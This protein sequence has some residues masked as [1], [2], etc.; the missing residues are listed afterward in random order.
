MRSYVKSALDA[1]TLAATPA[2]GTQI[3]SSTDT[4]FTLFYGKFRSQ[5]PKLSKP[6]SSIENKIKESRNSAP[7]ASP[8]SVLWQEY[9]SLLHDCQ[10]SYFGCRSQLLLPSVR[11]AVQELAQNHKRDHCGLVR[12]GCAFL[13]H[14]CEDEYQLFH[15]FFDQD[16]EHLK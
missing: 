5:A 13:L 8:S 7:S 3:K 4:A 9:E 2:P 11:S 15:Q 12:A 6:L 10:N 16:S 14:I 1:A